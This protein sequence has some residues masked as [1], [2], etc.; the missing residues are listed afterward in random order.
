MNLTNL[1][2][3]VRTRLGLPASDAFFSD[4]NLTDLV[5]AGLTYVTGKHDWYWL[6][7]AETLTTTASTESLATAATSQRTIALYDSTGVQLEWKSLSDLVKIPA[8][9]K[10]D[11]HRFFGY[12]GSTIV[13]RPVPNSGATAL[14][15]IYRGT[16]PRLVTGS[17]TPLMPSQFHDVI[18]DFACYFS[19]LRQGDLNGAAKWQESGE[20]WVTLMIESADRYADSVGGGARTEGAQGRETK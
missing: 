14:T 18:A 17:D 8:A 5:N 7:T 6:E 16:E 11:V 2:S 4:Q 19:M 9:A 12:K 10:A 15:H 13:L 1:L 20:A 3:A